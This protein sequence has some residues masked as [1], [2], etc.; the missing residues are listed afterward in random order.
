MRPLICIVL[1]VTAS[2]LPGIAAADPAAQF[3]LAQSQL[4][5]GQYAQ[6]LATFSSLHQEYP[7]DVDYAFGRGQALAR[8]GR[9]T[10]ALEQLERALALAPDYEDIRRER[11]NVLARLSAGSE[12][13]YR[14]L[15]TIGAGVDT[16]SN[17]LPGWNN[18]FAELQ[19]EHDDRQR[20]AV[21][22]SRDARN[23]VGDLSTSI[24]GDFSFASAWYAGAN[25]SIASSPVFQPKTGVSLHAGRKLGDGWSATLRYRH[26]DYESATVSS[27]AGGAEYYFADF[28]VA[29]EITASR[30]QGASGFA[31]H[32]LTGNWFYSDQSS[33]GITVGGGSEAESI[34]PNQVLETDVNSASLSGR[35]Q[36]T[37]RLGL[38]WWAGIHDQG[39]FYRR[40]FLGMAVSIGL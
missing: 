14:W 10:E 30:L 33:V 26:R 37:K 18:Q 1:V 31:S 32:V 29:Y 38:Q 13:R 21:G 11:Q 9:D 39:D 27:F 16:L 2:V 3:A 7:D 22:V 6:A 35:H 34:G 19:Y 24:R 25:I 28:R 20:Y 17:G 12:E 8:L 36:F 23:S 15:L 5:D 4:R 40:R